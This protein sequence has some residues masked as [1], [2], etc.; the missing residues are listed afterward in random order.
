MTRLL[1]PPQTE[2]VPTPVDVAYVHAWRADRRGNAIL[3]GHKGADRLLALAARKTVVSCE[4]LVD[5]ITATGVDADLT[6]SLVDMVIHAPGGARPGACLPGYEANWPALLD[7]T[8][9]ERED[10][11]GWARDQ[12]RNVQ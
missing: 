1:V 12:V 3:G 10:V 9:L 6:E 8:T 11:L 7:Y 5:D 4:E 2:D